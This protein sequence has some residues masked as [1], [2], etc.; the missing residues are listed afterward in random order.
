MNL[1]DYNRKVI[2]TL[3]QHISLKTFFLTNCESNK[4]QKINIV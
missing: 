2:K 3:I 4:T 1:R